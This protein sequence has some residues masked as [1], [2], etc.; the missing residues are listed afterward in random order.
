MAARCRN[1]KLRIAP[2]VY[3]PMPLKESSVASSDGSWPPWRLDRLARDRLQARGPDV[4]AE[5]IPRRRDFVGRRVG[6]HRERRVLGEPLLIL[7]QHAID[8]RLLQHD[9]RHQDVI[10]V[11]GVAP[12]QVASV[13]AIP[14]EQVTAEALPFGGGGHHGGCGSLTCRHAAPGAG[15]RGRPHIISHVKI[16]TK[17]GDAGET[18]LFDGTRV[19]KTDPRVG[20]YGEVDELQACL[21]AARA[22]GPAARPR[23]DVRD[24]A[25]RPVRRRRPAGRSSHRIAAR[26]DKAVVTTP[27]SP[28]SKRGSMDSTRSCRRCAIS[29]SPAGRRRAQRCTSPAL[30]AGGPSGPCSTSARR[31]WSRWS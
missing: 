8:L 26:V 1:A 20:A 5:R 10:R 25:A 9:L 17:T 23:R 11:V 12:R 28:A 6:Q 16:Y 21:G 19:S 14:A 30:S 24:A 7:R 2:A 22:A 31:R 27:T 3:W 29:S 18:S 13:C 4:V 15:P